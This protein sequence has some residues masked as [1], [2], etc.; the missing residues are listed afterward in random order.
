[1]HEI[2]KILGRKEAL[3]LDPPIC[4]VVILLSVADPGYSMGERQPHGT[5][6][7]LLFGLFF[8]RKCMKMKE[9]D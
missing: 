8:F 6:E 9:M 5:A 7:L 3:P 2:G 1:M 4:S